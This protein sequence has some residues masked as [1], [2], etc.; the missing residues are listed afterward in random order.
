MYKKPIIIYV[1]IALMGLS[2]AC[3][4]WLGL[5]PENNIVKEDYWVSKEN[6]HSA[7]VGCYAQMLDGSFTDKL[8]LWGEL[9]TDELDMSYVK[10]DASALEFDKIQNGVISSTYTAFNWKMFYKTINQ[11]NTVLEYAKV[12]QK[13]DATYSYAQLK[14]DE[15]EMLGLRSLVYFYLVR[16]YGEVPLMTKAV[17]SDDQ[18]ISIAKS[19]MGDILRQITTDLDTAEK[20]AYPSYGSLVYNKGRMT[21]YG[22]NTLQADIYLWNSNYTKCIEACNKVLNSGQY[23]LVTTST[24]DTSTT[25]NWFTSIFYEGNSNESIFE[26]QFNSSKA[27]PFYKYFSA[28]SGYKYFSASSYVSSDQTLFPTIS[29]STMQPDLRAKNAS[30]FATTSLTIW[31]YTGTSTNGT[32]LRSEAA[33][34]A[35]WIVYRLADVYLMRAEAYN[36]LDSRSTAEDRIMADDLLAVQRRAFA[37][38][39]AVI[40]TFGDKD[41][42]ADLILKERQKEFLFEGKRW[43]DVLRNARRDN[44]R[45]KELIFTMIANSAASSLQNELIKRYTDTLSLYYPLPQSDILADPNL[46]QNKYYDASNQ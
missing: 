29:G 7:I 9:R 33:F 32:S 6:V 14:A 36:Q 3:T 8:F 26:L 41:Q 37:M 42:M 28:A 27:N 19:S 4:D 30:S 24:S 40:D 15:A 38:S 13:L 12:A 1:A 34:Y 44:Y 20:Y 35:H 23:G 45:R 21:L 25:N 22:I 10:S 18:D 17:V 39:G 31:K 11:C 46:K 16:A 2:W 5:K 43:F